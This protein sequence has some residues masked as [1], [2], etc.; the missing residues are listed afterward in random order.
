MSA[1][2]GRAELDRALG[3]HLSDAQWAAVSAPLE[4][5]VI[6]AGAG[7]GKTT[8][9]SARVAYLVGSGQV[10]A[11]RVL[12]LTFTNK[13]AGQ[14]L[15]S[16]RTSLADLPEQSIA[17]DQALEPTVMTYHG[18][19]GRIVSEFGLRIGREPD[20][21]LLVDSRRYVH[22]YRLVCGVDV[23]GTDVPGTGELRTDAPATQTLGRALATLGKQP[24]TITEN[25]LDLDGELSELGIEPQELI[26]HDRVLITQLQAMG[27]ERGIGKQ[28]REAAEKRITLARLIVEWRAYKARD[29]LWEY[30]D[31]LRLALEIVERFPETATA[32]RHR[33]DVVLLDEYQ[34]TSITQRSLLQAIFGRGHPVT[35]VGD[36]CQAIYGWRGASVDNIDSFPIHFPRSDGSPARRYALAENRRSG[37]AVLHVANQIAA[38][39]RQ[40]HTG[41]EPLVAA[42][43]S[44]PATVRV[45]L[46]DTIHDEVE[47]LAHSIKVAHEAASARRS[48]GSTDSVAVLC[49]TGADI[50]RVDRALH[51]LGVPTQ[52]HGA[53]ALLADPAVAD[54]RALVEVAHEPTA[55]PALVRLLTGARW[56]VGARD[57]AALGARARELAGGRGRAQTDTVEQ[58]LEEAV[59]GSDPVDVVS[60]A[61]AIVD[62]GDRTRYSP[63]AL[64][65]FGELSAIIDDVRSGAGAPVVEVIGRAIDLLGVE[66]EAAVHDPTGGSSAALADFRLLA[67]TMAD[68]EGRIG[69]GGFIAR[70]RDAER[71]DI[72]ISHTR[73]ALDGAVQLMTV[74][75]AKGL[76]FGSVFM[77]FVS[78]GAFPGG[79]SRGRWTTGASIVPWPLRSDAAPDLA[80]F[81]GSADES[82]NQQHERYKE[83]TQRL[84]DR[85]HERL[86]YVGLTRAE[87]SVS[88]TGHWWA[89]GGEKPRGPHR[90]LL[91]I[92]QAVEESDPDRCQ[93]VAWAPAP[94]EGARN[95]ASASN[96]TPWPQ[97]VEPTARAALLRAVDAVRSAAQTSSTYEPAL[98]LA[99]A[100]SDD[101]WDQRVARWH[102]AFA[103]LVEEGGNHSTERVVNLGSHVGASTFLRA[104]KE[105][106]QLALDVAR[107]MPRQ[108]S[109]AASRGVAW[110]AWVETV[111][112]QQSLWGIEDLPGAV[113]ADISSD[114]RLE[115]LK[116]TFL[117]SSYAG[118]RPVAVERPFALVINGR[119]INGRMDAVFLID[120][121]YEVV[122]WKTGGTASVDPRQLAIYRLAWSHIAGVPWTQV[123]AAFYLVATG[124]EIR[125]DTDAEV[126]ALLSLG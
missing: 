39:L 46:F 51:R 2:F 89:S 60:L 122:D 93:V 79:R 33:Y 27:A 4:P 31:Y 88:V 119:V 28:I 69:L 10:D 125:P 22:A 35:A 81:P 75:A 99:V 80:V 77:P 29:D 15:T 91:Q 50:R 74:Y 86:A 65:S 42:T 95:P 40:E 21:T 121:R 84:V 25:M 92:K 6:I 5:A 43:A 26:A 54:V 82:L 49:T 68:S 83:A 32:I 41:T 61:E 123:D 108:P 97:A 107:P 19:A 78:D 111:F 57:L 117:R 76:E 110:H 112:G 44:D 1:S 17:P 34:D 56:R 116:S 73:P 64:R 52:V 70:L 94:A 90:F 48:A 11:D 124:E 3:F 8:S 23:L 18:F 96:R 14:L 16:I 9:M 53:A 24:A 12:G 101:V 7:T 20:A 13:A 38:Q 118:M 72:V 103:A 87:R 55:N 98:P 120:G 30:S 59:A 114:E 115:E 67:S 45:G 104:L 58:A 109:Q 106:D 71:F 102:D 100:P 85:D 63:A 37:P 62:P 113:D 47:Y 66:V 105:P 126:Q 36:P